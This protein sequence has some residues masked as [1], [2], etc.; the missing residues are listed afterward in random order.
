M[1][2]ENVLTALMERLSTPELETKVVMTLVRFRPGTTVNVHR[3]ADEHVHVDYDLNAPIS[4]VVIS[5]LLAVSIVRAEKSKRTFPAELDVVWGEVE[6]LVPPDF[7]DAFYE[8]L[9]QKKLR[10]VDSPVH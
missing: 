5:F 7:R 10:P 8:F 1:W 4:H 2:R 3:C 9:V 6:E